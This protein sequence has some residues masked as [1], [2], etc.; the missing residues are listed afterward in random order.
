MTIFTMPAPVRKASIATKR[1][2]V[3]MDE[4]VMG[5]VL[6]VSPMGEYDKRVVILTKECGKISAFARG[7]RKPNSPL[8]AC[9]QPF[10]FG[11]FSLYRGRNSFTIKSAKVINYFTELREEVEDVYMG[12]YFC[13]F[14]SYF[15]KENLD[16]AEILKL[17]YQSL[18]ALKVPSLNRELVRYIFELKLM[19]VNGEAPRVFSCI[20][21]GS[22]EKLHGFLSQEAGIV[23]EDC[24]S[25]VKERVI[26]VRETTAYTMQFIIGASIEK[27]YTF[28]VSNEVQE[29]LGRALRQ[30]LKDHVGVSFHSLELID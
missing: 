14:A 22:K 10:T 2:E 21:C 17:L 8:L 24:M 13:E 20:Q 16:A 1:N 28:T 19:T 12:L 23:C 26:T 6:S 5:M 29:E 9:T 27:L 11:E 15:T 7:A 3:N 25:L 18:R 4:T 30:Y